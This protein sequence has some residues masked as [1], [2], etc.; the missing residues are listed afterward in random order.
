M[1]LECFKYHTFD[2]Y[3]FQ[4]S[5]KVLCIRKMYQNYQISRA[6]LLLLVT[7]YA[8]N[9]QPKEDTFLLTSENVQLASSD[10]NFAEL[11]QCSS[12]ELKQISNDYEVCHRQKVEKI[13]QQFMER[14][15]KG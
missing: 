1:Y 4:F 6:V 7:C 13:E 12:S 11:P 14:V 10:R 8:R 15:R 2:K 9:V 3:L 5:A